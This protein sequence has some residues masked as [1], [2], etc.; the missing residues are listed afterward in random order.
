MTQPLYTGISDAFG[1]APT[2]YSSIL[3]FA[4]GS[5][6][7]AIAQNM[8]TVVIGRVF[9]GLGGG[10]MDLMAEVI[11]ADMTTLQ[12]RSLYLGL[13]AIP[14]AVGGI[15]GP[16][17]GA[18]LSTN[19]SWRWI[20]WINLP[21]LGAAFILLALFLRLR[22]IDTPIVDKLKRLDWGG[23]ILSL[24]G[25]T[26]FI[27]PLSWA[28]ALYPWASWQTLLPLFVGIA[29]IVIFVL[30]EFKIPQFPIFPLRLFSSTSINLSLVG[31]FVYGA[32]LYSLLQYIPLLYQAIK[33]QTA[34]ESAVS[35]LP[36]SVI[37]VVFAVLGVIMVGVIGKGYRW[38]LRTCWV[39]LTV[40]TGLLGLV[41]PETPT[42]ML[43]GLPVLWGAAIG[44]LM[45]LLHL[46][47][48]AGVTNVDDTGLIIGLLLMVR[49]C[50]GVVGLALSAS[51]FSSVFTSS[52]RNVELGG[53]LAV[54]EDASRAI[55]FI[56]H[57]KSSNAA[58]ESL[59]P[60]LH[61]YAMAMRPIFYAMTGLSA[62]GLL[63]SIFTKDESLK[64][65]DLGRQ[66]FEE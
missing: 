21:I 51:I 37:S 34:I 20:G 59:E 62:V 1:R 13:L 42:S 32:S 7:F 45:R 47:M 38:A 12:E 31:N 48:Q 29:L 54:V 16:T 44:A 5:V 39:I 55:G 50:G 56:P 11:V 25:A 9:Q 61:A 65:T 3:L 52:I 2:L 4:L 19:L 24:V 18:L 64:R 66:H 28:N 33:L 60:V 46:P 23:A 58:P 40:G 26:I 49:Q 17:L 22:R 35:L 53:P 8:T 14:T 57:L 10:G 15:L 27:V 43:M 41:G 30:Y 63:T 36:T 6:V